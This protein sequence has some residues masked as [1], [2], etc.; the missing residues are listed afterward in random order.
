MAFAPV[1]LGHDAGVHVDP[2]DPVTSQIDNLTLA[3]PGILRKLP[4]GTSDF[5]SL[6]QTSEE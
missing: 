6:L 3:Y 1:Q 5:H 2:E 4:G